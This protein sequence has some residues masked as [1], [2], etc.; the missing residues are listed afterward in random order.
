[1]NIAFLFGFCAVGS[2]D[3]IVHCM[4]MCGRCAGYHIT[5]ALVGLAARGKRKACGENDDDGLYALHGTGF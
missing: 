2:F 1:M 3:L 4:Q 5:M